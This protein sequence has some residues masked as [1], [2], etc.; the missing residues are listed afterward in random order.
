M[1]LAAETDHDVA[2]ACSELD[3]AVAILDR[4]FPLEHKPNVRAAMAAERDKYRQ[5]LESCGR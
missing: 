1:G 3:T 4:A 2:R 5:R